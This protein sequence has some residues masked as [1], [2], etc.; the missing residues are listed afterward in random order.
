MFNSTTNCPQ[1]CS[2]NWSR[3]HWYYNQ[4]D[5]QVYCLIVSCQ[6]SA[7]VSLI[8][9][10]FTDTVRRW[11]FGLR[12]CCWVKW[13]LWF[14]WTMRTYN[15]LHKLYIVMNKQ[16]ILW[17]Q[18]SR[19]F[20]RKTLFIQLCIS[21][22]PK[23]YCV[24]RAQNCEPYPWWKTRLPTVNL[25]SNPSSRIP[26]CISTPFPGIWRTIM[27]NAR[28]ALDKF[29]DDG[30]SHCARPCLQF[31]SEGV[32]AA[33]QKK[34]KTSC[35]VWNSESAECWGGVFADR[36]LVRPR[37]TPT[38]SF[39]C[40]CAFVNEEILVPW[41]DIAVSWADSASSLPSA[42]R[43]VTQSSRNPIGPPAGVSL[44]S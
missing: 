25:M 1:K 6:C 8:F 28:T 42:P 15:K 41:W 13:R 34:N 12:S 16:V 4:G 11:H 44:P 21:G 5:G 31:T 7:S 29:D 10:C 26:S 20:Q 39:W 2:T 3:W 43:T 22:A 36:L 17:N 18:Q 32:C 9:L 19:G 40:L 14:R 35:Q 27:E 33:P 24:H 37:P 23:W 38:P 30:E